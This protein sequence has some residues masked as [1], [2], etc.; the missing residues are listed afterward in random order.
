MRIGIV[1]DSGVGKT[2]FVQKLCKIQNKDIEWTVGCSME[3]YQYRSECI[4]IL[5]IGGASKYT[6]S[7]RVLYQNLDG[8]LYMYDKS[9]QQ[10]YRNIKKWIR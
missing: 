9:N 6:F 3:I 10:S 5:D 4:E 1:G 7:R 2:T 8:V